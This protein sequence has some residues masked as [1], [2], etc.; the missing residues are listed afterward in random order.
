VVVFLT[1]VEVGEFPLLGDYT[2]QVPSPAQDPT[3]VELEQE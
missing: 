1:E 3:N 2:V